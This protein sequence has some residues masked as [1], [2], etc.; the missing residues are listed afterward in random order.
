MFL[1]YKP[2]LLFVV[3]V[4]VSGCTLNKSIALYD[5]NRLTVETP[6]IMKLPVEIDVVYYNG[7][8]A[9]FMTPFQPVIEYL[10]KPGPQL[11]GLRYSDLYTNTDNDN[12]TIKSNIVFLQFQAKPNKIYT[13]QFT[14]PVDLQAAEQYAAD[15]Q[16]KLFEKN[17]LVAE[18]VQQNEELTLGLSSLFS[19]NPPAFDETDNEQQQESPLQQLKYWWQQ[20]SSVDKEAF[21]HWIDQIND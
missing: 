7:K 11:I 12:Q 17:A 13:T 1:H 9:R 6:S 10:L 3:A 5:K 15:F 20:A 21:E 18:S 2:V 19:A 14:R 4:L 16:L 8:N